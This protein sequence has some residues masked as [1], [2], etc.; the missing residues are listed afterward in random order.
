MDTNNEVLEFDCTV[1]VYP[2]TDARGY[3]RVR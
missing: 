2:P 3:W 1:R